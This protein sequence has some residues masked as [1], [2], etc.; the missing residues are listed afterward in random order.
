[1]RGLLQ[2]EP[3]NNQAKELERLIDKAM[4]KGDR[5]LAICS[6][7]PLRPGALGHTAHIPLHT[8]TVLYQTYLPRV[9]VALEPQP[10]DS[11]YRSPSS[12]EG[13]VVRAGDGTDPLT[14]PSLLFQ[15]DW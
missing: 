8:H 10:S 2:T 12:V 7:S 14:S 5:P 11:T 4:K 3:Q 9:S 15:M 13:S 6:S 1:M